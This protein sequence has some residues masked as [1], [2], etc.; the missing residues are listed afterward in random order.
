MLKKANNLERVFFYMHQT[1]LASGCETPTLMLCIF[2]PLPLSKPAQMLHKFGKVEQFCTSNAP[3]WTILHNIGSSALS[4]WHII[5]LFCIISVRAPNCS[6]YSLP[7]LRCIS[8]DKNAPKHFLMPF[9][10]TM[11]HLQCT[12]MS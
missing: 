1:C 4:L 9:F 10:D 7:Q 5:D 8:S 6:P 11:I 2:S 12:F 3:Y